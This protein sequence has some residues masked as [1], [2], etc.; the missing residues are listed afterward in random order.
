MQ[1]NVSYEYEIVSGLEQHL[2]LDEA[3]TRKEARVIKRRLDSQKP[4]EK[5]RIVQHRY[6]V[7]TKQIR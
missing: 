1:K 6:T 5:H 2:V 4:Q 7:E 3:G